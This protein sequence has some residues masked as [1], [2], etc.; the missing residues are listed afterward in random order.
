MNQRAILFAGGGTLGHVFPNVAIAEALA[1]LRPDLGAQFLVSERPDDAA[2]LGRLG[3]AYTRSSVRPLPRMTRPLEVAG[4]LISWRRAVAAARALVASRRIAAVVASGGFVSGPGIVAAARAG[5][6]RAL[7]NLDAVP[8]KANRRLV[9]TASRVFSVVPSAELPGAI[10]IGLPLR[11]AS[12]GHGTPPEAR[13]VLGLGLDLQLPMLFVTGATHGAESIVRMMIAWC[14]SAALRPALASWQV[15]HQCGHVSPEPLTRAYAA[16][17]VR[18]TV[19]ATLEQI[20]AAFCAA[21]L[22]IARSGAGTVAE[23]WANAAPTV[24]LPNPYH[25]DH[26]Q[27]HNAEPMVAAGG[28]VALEDRIDPDGN[29]GTTVPAIVELMRDGGRRDRMR[30]ALVAAPPPDGA[31]VVAAWISSAVGA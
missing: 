14:E 20:G 15:L 12:R 31:A 2:V 19:V 29:L 21:D 7:V 22:V 8:G 30:A 6:P 23:A 16:A 13:A 26:H 25:S 17:G 28:A 27:L 1:K 4:F 11:A 10:A 3:Y 5:L 24:F 9:K 18:A